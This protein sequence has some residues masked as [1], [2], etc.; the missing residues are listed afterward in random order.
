MADKNKT[1]YSS[2]DYALMLTLFSASG[3]CFAIGYTEFAQSNLSSSIAILTGI[4]TML[5]FLVFGVPCSYT[6]EETTLR[7]RN[8]LVSHRVSYRDI[9]DVRESSGVIPSLTPSQR[10]VEIRSQR[11]VAIINPR[12]REAFI[13]DLALKV[14]EYRPKEDAT[15]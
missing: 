14:T 11:G 3:I 1:Y 13:H 4:G 15:H 12:D 2:L 5:L 8:G 10:S 6:L 9:L 7:I